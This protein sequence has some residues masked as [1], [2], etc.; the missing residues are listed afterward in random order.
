M[1]D[2]YTAVK[3]NDLTNKVVTTQQAWNDASGYLFR[4]NDLTSETMKIMG[5]SVFSEAAN[6]MKFGH[7]KY[8]LMPYGADAGEDLSRFVYL[9]ENGNMTGEDNPTPHFSSVKGII[10]FLET[11]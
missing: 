2:L 6:E 8:V 5:Y 7:W 3:I 4:S 1:K 11:V 9:D 10:W